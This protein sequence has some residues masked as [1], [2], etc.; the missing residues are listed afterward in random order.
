MFSRAWLNNLCLVGVIAVVVPMSAAE[1]PARKP[2]HEVRASGGMVVSDSE[3]ASRVGR[4]VL[5]DGGNAVDAA[6]ATA[7]ALAVTWPE[8][9]NIGGGGFM[10]IHP[11]TGQTPVCIDYRET[12]PLAA[13]ETMFT[14]DDSRYKGKAVGVPG[15]VRG[16]AL[17]HQTFGKLAWNR[18]VTPAAD[19][20]EQGFIVDAWLAHSTNSILETPDVRESNRYAELRRVYGRADSGVWKVGDT[21][22]LPDLAKTLRAIAADGA[23]AFYEGKIADQFVAQMKRGNGLITKQDLAGYEAKLREPIRG[24]YR[25]YELFGPPPPSSGGVCVIEAMNML[26]PFRLRE[27][28]R[29]GSRNMHLITEAM[30]RAFC[31]RARYLADPEFA[32]IPSHLTTKAHA[33]ELADSIDFDRATPSE[34][35]APEIAIAPESTDTTHFSVI[36]RNGM[37]VSNTYTLEASWGS[38]IVVAG[39]GF[40]LNNEMG[41]FNWERGVTTRGGQIGTTP[42]LIEPGKRMLSSQS[43]FI[44]TRDGKAFLLTGSPGGRTIINTVLGN[45]LNVLEFEMT[46]ADAIDAPRMH[47]QWFPDEL[48]FEGSKSPEHA[49]AIEQLR[50]KGHTVLHRDRQGSAH[51]VQVDQA[52]GQFIG[53]ADWR[54]GGAAIGANSEVVE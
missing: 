34:T 5:A 35:L 19:L 29:Y 28:P 14:K 4:D 11:G 15:T 17:A 50:M 53:V 49:D 31:D 13:T 12:A 2:I 46:L 30:R 7:F 18:V 54:R 9:G 24:T 48:R 52:T 43:P 8:A 47:H 32:N 38:R 41:D 21:M 25:E 44:V 37:A 33:A 26:E 36:D 20:A 23:D 39:A 22:V 51:S 42:N 27:H 16:L 10:M 6:V 40:V 3:I 45:L 1:P